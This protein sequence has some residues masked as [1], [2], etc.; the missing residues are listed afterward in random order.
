VIVNI[1]SLHY[2]SSDSNNILAKGGS[3]GNSAILLPSLVNNPSSSN[4]S[5][6]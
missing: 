5:N 2:R 3:N 6:A 1:S 4:A